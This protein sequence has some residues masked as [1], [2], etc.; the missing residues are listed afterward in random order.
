MELDFPH[1][2]KNLLTGEWVLVSPHRTKRPWQGKVEKPPL[3]Q[4]PPYDPECYLCPGNARAGG[5]INPEYSSTNVFT[6]DF[7]ALMPETTGDVR[8]GHD[9]FQ[10]Q[11]VQGTCR[12]LVFSPRH[13]LSLARMSLD[14]IGLVIQMWCEQA[15]YLGKTY[16]WVQIFENR[17]EMMGS[18]MPHPHGQVWA[19]D[20]L[21]NEPYKE[22][23]Q[24]QE[25]HHEHDGVLL[26]DYLKLE[27]E[28]QQRIVV[29]NEH[30]VALV[31]FWAVWPFE[32][33]LLPRE[34][35]CRLQDMTQSQI[36]TLAEILKRLL[37]KY[38]NLFE[39]PFPYSM[40]WHPAPNLDADLSFWQLHAHFY[41]PLLRSAT[42]KKF[43]VGYEMLAEAQRDLTAE[44]AAQRLRDLPD[45][46]YSE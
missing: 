24:Q 18:S 42:V 23:I 5:V 27:I 30:W 22:F 31:P 36:I 10:T 37:V 34:T 21:P 14:E 43:L 12:V 39:S 15:E 13:D 1:R 44:Q 29:E 6:N 2:R 26:L 7:A 8:T 4:L 35:I 17:G 32:T 45:T 9:L 28:Q 20:Q 33:L 25:Y 19:S 46:H 38:E 16:Q 41:P 3:I 40:G 11:F